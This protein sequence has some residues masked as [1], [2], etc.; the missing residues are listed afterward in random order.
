MSP[1]F[2]TNGFYGSFQA[3]QA[4]ALAVSFSY[5]A[6]ILSRINL[7]ALNGPSAASD[8]KFPFLGGIVWGNENLGLYPGGY[9]Y[10]PLG[11]TCETPPLDH[12]RMFS[13]KNSFSAATN[14]GPTYLQSAIWRYDPILQALTA[15]WINP[16]RSETQTKIVLAHRVE[17]QE[18]PTFV[19]VGD[20]EA[21]LE[22][23]EGM[24][25][26]HVV[27]FQ[28]VPLGKHKAKA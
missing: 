15:Q 3:S 28:C 24:G 16:D 4:D 20:V 13:T 26:F 6:T 9:A 2:N 10:I 12:P 1:V 23:A 19:L 27:T 21:V 14:D 7:R 11:G 18:P 8:S 25:S 17:Y 5:S 22:H